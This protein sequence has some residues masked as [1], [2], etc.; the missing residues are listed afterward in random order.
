M[1]QVSPT[2]DNASARKT[3]LHVLAFL[4]EPERS[5]MN[6]SRLADQFDNVRV[7]VAS[8]LS[9]AEP[10]L[11]EAEV[12]ITIGN[13]MG[14]IADE[15]YRKAPALKWVQSF[16]TGVDNIKGH[17][18]LAD[19]VIITNVHGI[20]GPQ[21]SEAAFAAMLSFARRLPETFRNQVE[22]R[23]QKFASDLIFGRKVGILGLG[24]IASDLAPRCQ[25]FGMTVTGI[26]GTLRDVE[27]IDHVFTTDRLEQA[28]ADLDY[29]VV[30]T[31]LSDK[32]R[33]LVNKKIFDAL[34]SRAV[35]INLSRGGVVNEDDL[36]QA[37]NNGDIAGAALDVFEQEPLATASPFWQHPRVMITPH[38]AGFHSGY[39][40]QAYRVIAANIE[41]YL[42]GGASSLHNQV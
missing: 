9:E 31:P 28:V 10:C 27:H 6:F 26:S 3:P 13:H 14:P 1:K 22:G 11:A 16:G 15:L 33:H 30:L 23:W 38:S 12:L 8:S 24:A 17:P 37:L 39:A 20:H 18:A 5:G 34:P 36:L 21:L 7:T 32:T 25:A 41:R 4:K 42:Q 29:L 35:L 40:E 19:D 2:T